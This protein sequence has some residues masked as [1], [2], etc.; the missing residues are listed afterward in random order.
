MPYTKWN[1]QSI[2]YLE[3]VPQFYRSTILCV[4]GA[5][6][7]SRHWAFQLKL[8]KDLNTRIIAVD[9]PGHGRSTGQPLKSIQDYSLFVKDLVEQLEIKHLSLIGHSMGS[10]ICLSLAVNCPSLVENLVLIGTAKQFKVAPW[11]LDSL[12]KGERPL[13]FIDL[14]YHNNTEKQVL[15]SA[16]EEF[17][18]TPINVLLNDFL[19]CQA[20]NLELPETGLNVPCL[21][22]FG[23]QDRLTPVKYVEPL[24]G[25]LPNH[26]LSIIPEA[27]HMVMIEQPTITNNEISSFLAITQEK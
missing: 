24:A 10:A 21:L 20:F 18:K 22:L 9:L 8:V 1:G 5:G 14:A 16:K 25:M 26:R 12:K 27:G 23:D 13:S 15:V 19:A 17:Q 7:N 6:G 4:H 3:A 2:F 11:L